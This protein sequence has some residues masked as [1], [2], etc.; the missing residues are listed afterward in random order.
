M[1]SFWLWVGHALVILGRLVVVRSLHLPLLH[2]VV[3]AY[4]LGKIGC[5][6]RIYCV[7]LVTRV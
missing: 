6:H 3:Y 5:V 2:L 4:L 7:M 1:G